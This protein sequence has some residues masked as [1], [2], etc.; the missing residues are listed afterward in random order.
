M[1]KKESYE[2]LWLQ[3]DGADFTFDNGASKLKMLLDIMQK[4]FLSMSEKW[5]SQ[6]QNSV[7][8]KKVITFGADMISSGSVDKKKLS[9]FLLND[10][11][12]S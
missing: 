3:Q 12:K 7:I 9:Y 5:N 4:G 8:C 1:K 10:E 11:R 6:Y 2:S